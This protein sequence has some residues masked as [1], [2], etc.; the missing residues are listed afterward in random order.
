MLRC[1]GHLC[2]R[3]ATKWRVLISQPGERQSAVGS[4]ALTNRQKEMNESLQAIGCPLTQLSVFMLSGARTGLC[5]DSFARLIAANNGHVRRES[6]SEMGGL[7]LTSE[8]GE[9]AITS[10]YRGFEFVYWRSVERGRRGGK[11]HGLVEKWR[12]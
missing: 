6:R 1:K 7:G 10:H 5:W 2:R 12:K 4:E 11:N 9:R 3:G 8:F